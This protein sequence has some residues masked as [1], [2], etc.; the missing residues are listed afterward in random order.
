M[1]G[2]AIAD[3]S[4]GRRHRKDLGDIDAL[5]ASIEK[6]GLLHPIVILPDNRLVV[7]ERRLAAFRKLKRDTIP[8][9]VAKNLEDAGK[10]IAAECEENTCRKAFT[11]EEAVVVGARIEKLAAKEA[12][13]REEKGTSED[14]KAGGRGKRK[15]PRQSL[16]RVSSQDEAK[17]T[18]AVAA[19]AVGMSRPTY[20]KAK[21]VVAAAKK[22][23]TL[24][25]TL[26][27]YKKALDLF[28]KGNRPQ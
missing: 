21:E 3:I 16:P 22:A 5:A 20:E 10:F 7:G 6:L 25:P 19:A 1:A 2:K 13:E 14:G 17:R 18:T 27:S 12:K 26:N 8:V 23:V 11:P 28:Q 24:M 4:V 9:N 15:N